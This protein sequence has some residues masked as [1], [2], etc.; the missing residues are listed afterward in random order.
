MILLQ[1]EIWQ[2]TKQKMIENWIGQ[3]QATECRQ[4]A[5]VVAVAAGNRL[6]AL[7]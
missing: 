1:Q 5:S 7:T 4:T 6:A 2:K 3:N